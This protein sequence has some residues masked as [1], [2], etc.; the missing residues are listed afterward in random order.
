MT[1][2]TT[3]ASLVAV[4]LRALAHS[5]DVLRIDV[6]LAAF[7]RLC[8][9][10]PASALAGLQLT[11]QARAEWRQRLS[12]GV[13]AELKGALAQA[14]QLWLHLSLDAQVP[15]IC[16]RCLS[17]YLE[18]VQVD[19]WFRLVADEATAAVEDEA[20]EEDVLVLEHRFNLHELLEDE[21]IMA[22]PLIPMHD[23]CPTQ[24][25]MSAGELD[26]V[27]VEKPNPFAALAALKKDGA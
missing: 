21:L 23:V 2:E 15:Q 22:L 10:V 18:L 13:A 6:P 26:E 1:S 5:A 4:D 8:A 20:S 12:D 25:R 7:T 11:G 16:Q 9:D 14:P 27:P 24:V 19:R 17:E 3:R